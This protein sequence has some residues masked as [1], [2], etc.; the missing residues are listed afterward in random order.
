VHV[1]PRD[2]V[3]PRRACAFRDW[4]QSHPEDRAA[5]GEHKGAAKRGFADA[6]SYNNAKAD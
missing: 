6:T 1:F 5:Y 3:E 4:R 2:A